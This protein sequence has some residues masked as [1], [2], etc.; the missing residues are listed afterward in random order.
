MLRCNSKLYRVNYRKFAGN[1]YNQIINENSFN[2]QTDV[3]I[4]YVCI[5]SLYKYCILYENNI[6][7]C[8]NI[9]ENG[10]DKTAS[11]DTNDLTDDIDNNDLTDDLVV[12]LKK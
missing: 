3:N 10:I 7:E 4:K 8:Y 1:N 2:A 12:I 11:I 5:I 6:V 9:N